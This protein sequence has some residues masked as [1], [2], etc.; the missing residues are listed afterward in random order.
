MILLDKISEIRDLAQLVVARAGIFV[1]GNFSSRSSEA[2]KVEQRLNIHRTP[3][4]LFVAS[5]FVFRK[6]TLTAAHQSASRKPH[7]TEPGGL[8]PVC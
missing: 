5:C 7:R 4:E 6:A 3:M 1:R 2:I 8:L